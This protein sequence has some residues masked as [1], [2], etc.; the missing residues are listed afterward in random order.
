LPPGDGVS[1]GSADGDANGSGVGV[2]TGDAGDPS[3]D[4][5]G[6]GSGDVEISGLDVAFGTG[7]GGGVPCG[8]GAVWANET[9]PV[10]KAIKA[11]AANAI[12]RKFKATPR[13]Q[14]TGETTTSGITFTSTVPSP[15]GR[16]SRPFGAE[17]P[18]V[19]E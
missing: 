4:G 17:L 6:V 13:N 15:Y 18:P 19:L 12:V 10:P 5:S 8:L 14:V 7:G 1:D 3:V 9:A 16:I 11:T 2:I